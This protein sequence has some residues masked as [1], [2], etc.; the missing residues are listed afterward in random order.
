MKH[1]WLE[2]FYRQWTTARGKRIQP[3][4]RTFRREWPKLLDEAGLHSAEDRKAAQ[5]EAEREEAKGNLK[6]HRVKARRNLILKIELPLQAETWLLGIFNRQLPTESLATS[7]AEIDI[8]ET[9]SHPRFPELWKGWC[10]SL[11]SSFTAGKIQRPLDWRYPTTV[12]TLLTLVYRLT[13]REWHEGALVRE[14]SHEIGLHSKGLERCRRTV[15]ACL[16]QLFGRQMSL[17]ALGIVLSDSRTDLAGV[18]TLHYAN[19]GQQ[20]FEKLK[21]VFSLSL[22]DL[23]RAKYATTTA[24]RILTVE[25]SKTTLRRLASLNGDGTTLLAACAFPTKA[26]I[27]LLALLPPNLPILHFGDTDPAGYHILSKLRETSPRPVLSFLMNR[28]PAKIRCPLTEYDEALLPRL[29]HDPLLYDVRENLVTTRDTGC[30]GDFEQETL[31]LPEI[32]TWPFYQLANSIPQVP[33][34]PISTCDS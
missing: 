31:G 12:Q 16:K 23:E 2:E 13:S 3:S 30:K 32:Q 25:N 20:T 15:E 9:W 29:I 10:R 28:R 8:A 11:K 7:L 19:G 17:S 34:S 26:L 18:F 33:H 24:Q 6:L 14:I 27:R 21:E 4:T 1:A 5:R 22:G